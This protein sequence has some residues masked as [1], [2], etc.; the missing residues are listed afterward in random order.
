MWHQHCDSCVLV[1]S[2]ACSTRT[3]ALHVQQEKSL[4]S[5]FSSNHNKVN[6]WSALTQTLTLFASF[7]SVCLYCTGERTPWPCYSSWHVH[8]FMWHCW[9]RLHKTLRTTPRGMWAHEPCVCVFVNTNHVH[10]IYLFKHT[11]WPWPE[12]PAILLGFI[13]LFCKPGCDCV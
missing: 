2:A 11:K 5:G 8:W 7:L 4:T 6:I 3:Y 10:V 13:Q 12:A 9:R 1:S